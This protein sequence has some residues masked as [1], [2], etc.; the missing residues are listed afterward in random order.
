[1][2]TAKQIDDFLSARPIAMAGV[3]RNPK[4]FGYVAFKELREKGLDL[5]PV[6]P[7]ATEINGIKAYNSV[8]TL[9]DGIKSLLIMTPKPQTASVVREARAKGIK[10]IWIQQMSDTPE[11][12]LELEGSGI[13]VI[14]KECI[15][16]FHNPTGLHKFH[17]RIKQFFGRLPK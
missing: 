1:M 3:S 16:M 15:M 5:I 12:I 4:K 2:A 14:T 13:N 11:A 7:G 8:A 17:R 6:N 10:N 9:P